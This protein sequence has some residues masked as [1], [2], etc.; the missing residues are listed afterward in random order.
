[1]KTILILTSLAAVASANAVNLLVNGGFEST[2]TTTNVG[3]TGIRKYNGGESLVGWTVGGV[4]VLGTDA[5]YTEASGAG[6][7]TFNANSGNTSV[8]LTGFGNTGLSDSISQS[9]ATTVGTTYNVSFF[10]GRQNSFDA[11]D[12]RYATPSTVVFSLNGGAPMSFTNSNTATAKINWTQFTT[13][14]VANST[15]T[16]VQFNNGTLDNNWVGIDDVSVEA[17]PEP[18]SFAALGVGAL[19]LLRRRAKRA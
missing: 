15:S 13:S 3:I 10:V 1:M 8:D 14:F 2:D 5:N 12:T 6:S 18:A 7:I 17:V 11:S 19:A 9:I 4:D 16:L